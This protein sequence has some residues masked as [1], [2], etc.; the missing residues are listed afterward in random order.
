MSVSAPVCPGDPAVI[1]SVAASAYRIPTDSP[2]S[3][4]TYEWDA[5]T[6]VV[7]EIKAAGTIGLGYT[8]ADVATTALIR[9]HLAGV[10]RGLDAMAIPGVWM[11]LGASIRNLGRPGIA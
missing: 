2:E 4:G 10:I 11:A 5:T 6:L 7:V 9:D 1:E 8:Y 3:D